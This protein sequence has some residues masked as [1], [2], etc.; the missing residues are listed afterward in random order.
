MEHIWYSNLNIDEC[1][2][3]LKNSVNNES[4]ISGNSRRN[5]GGKTKGHKFRLWKRQIQYQN[6]F[7]SIFYGNLETDG[8]GT[9]I[10]GDFGLD[11][12]VKVILYL[13]YGFVIAM[14][15]FLYIST[16]TKLIPGTE[17][18]DYIPPFFYSVPFLAL[19]AL[20]GF[21]KVLMWLGKK[22]QKYIIDFL[23]ITLNA[24]IQI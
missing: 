3:N 16:L 15:I 19:L 18:H 9:R 4:W 8:T 21:A 24:H 20:Y 11:S 10:S 13:M 12:T 5:I 1:I 14:G 6:S 17:N 7:G 22:E 2:S 23:E